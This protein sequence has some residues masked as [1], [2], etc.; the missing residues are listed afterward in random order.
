LYF[1]SLERNEKF[2]FSG[3]ASNNAGA[4]HGGMTRDTKLFIQYSKTCHLRTPLL[5]VKC[6]LSKDKEKNECITVFSQ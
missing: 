6:G 4:G 5:S 1:T 3:Y 2:V